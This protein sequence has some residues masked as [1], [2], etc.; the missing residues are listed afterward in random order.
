MAFVNKGDT[1]SIYVK[2]GKFIKSFVANGNYCCPATLKSVIIPAY[3]SDYDNEI[4]KY[5]IVRK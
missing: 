1:V 2:N 4:H 3:M 5:M